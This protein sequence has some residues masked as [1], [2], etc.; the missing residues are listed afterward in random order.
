MRFSID[1]HSWTRDGG[2][3]VRSGFAATLCGREPANWQ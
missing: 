2:S 3:Y 1:R